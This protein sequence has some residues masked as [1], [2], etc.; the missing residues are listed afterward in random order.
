ML[1]AMAGPDSRSPIAIAEPGSIFA[2]SLERDFTG[3]RVAWG[4][5]LGEFPVD[6]RI[7]ATVN[8]QRSVF[9]QMGCMVDD[10][11][12]DF[13][14]ADEIFKTWRAWA[15]EAQFDELVKTHG[16]QVK[17]TVVWNV[18]EGRRLTG[19]QIS[20][21]EIKRTELYHRVRQHME[22]YEFLVLPVTQVPPFDV[23]QEFV[24]EING[25]QMETYIDWMKSCYYITVTG[26][27]AISVPCGFTAEGLPVG[28]QIVG[29]H[30]DDFG[31]LQLA[32]AFQEATGGIW[33]KRPPVVA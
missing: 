28:L 10:S 25:V 18:E 6:P 22:E 5:D 33:Q 20:R 8:R 16:D 24:A 21:A 15:F 30:Q 19:P 17:K 32:Y 31:V 12:P 29:R 13:G 2:G 26:L 1:S 11:S 9:E 27:P 3:V 14:G 7:M 4:G 23:S